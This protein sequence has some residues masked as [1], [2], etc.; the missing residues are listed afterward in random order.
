M[1]KIN[2]AS[3]GG[4]ESKNPTMRAV[5]L[6]RN[7]HTRMTKPPQ[8]AKPTPFRPNQEKAGS[9]G[10]GAPQCF[11]RWR[12]RHPS[13]TG[14]VS[15]RSSAPFRSRVGAILH[16]YPNHFG[17]EYPRITYSSGSSEVLK[18]LCQ[19]REGK[20]HDILVQAWVGLG[21][22]ML[23]ACGRWGLRSSACLQQWRGFPVEITSGPWSWRV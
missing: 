9:K 2:G 20:I 13:P 18:V 16:F 8:H 22:V 17:A 12:H 21:S 6:F 11:L 5:C 10:F 3:I 15:S 23:T 19:V 4:P 1:S 14:S 7:S